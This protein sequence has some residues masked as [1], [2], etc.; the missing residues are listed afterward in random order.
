MADLPHTYPFRFV[1]PRRASGSGAGPTV[2]PSVDSALPGPRI[3][4]RAAASQGYPLSLAIEAMAQSVL[5]R[6]PGVGEESGDVPDGGRRA[7][8]AGIEG[9]K[10]L[11]AIRPG[12]RLEGRSELQGRFGPALKVRC[13]LVREGEPVAEATLLL[14]LG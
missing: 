11:A 13:T 12:D 8:L 10:L 14:T 5:L 6:P 2:A 9:A 3:G 7:Q 1:E 4:G